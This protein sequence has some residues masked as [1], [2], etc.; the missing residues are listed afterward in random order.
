MTRPPAVT[1]IPA[2]ETTKSPAGEQRRTAEATGL[3]AAVGAITSQAVLITALLYYFGWVRSHARLGYFGIDPGLVGY[4]TPDYVLYSINVAFLPF[5]YAAL[6]ILALLG[7]HR[8]V[9]LPTLNRAASTPPSDT[10]GD[11]VQRL[12]RRFVVMAHT[13]AVM[14]ALTA[15][16]GIVFPAQVGIPLGITLP[17]LLV[18]SVSLFGYLGHL[19]AKYPEQLAWRVRQPQV[20]PNSR[21]QTL[22]LLSIGL[23]ASLWAVSL[24]GDH[25]GTRTAI[26]MAARLPYQSE[27]VVY[28]TT[29]IALNGPGVSVTEITQPGTKYHYQY[30]G[31][32]LLAHSTDKYIL[33]PMYWQHGRDRVFLIRDDDTVR[34]DIAAM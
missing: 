10:S 17:L 33:L 15:I 32:R 27:V 21:V 8:M 14:L 19:R 16:I 29:R 6:V 23:L 24:Y 26:D 3:L 28:S 1:A 9:V 5:T 11:G 30:N 4:S 25:T 2:D 31:L 13:L 20:A 22:V 18:A 12:I 7:L 34:I